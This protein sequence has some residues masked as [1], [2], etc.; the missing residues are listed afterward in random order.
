[1]RFGI[2]Y[3]NIQTIMFIYHWLDI[4]NYWFRYHS[5]FCSGRLSRRLSSLTLCRFIVFDFLSEVCFSCFGTSSAVIF[6]SR[7]VR[8][9]LK[10]FSSSSLPHVRAAMAW[11]VGRSTR[12]FSACS[13]F[14]VFIVS[15]IFVKE[16][17]LINEVGNMA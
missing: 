2:L 13:L 15:Y 11:S 14:I 16:N 17:V 7:V 8:F 6:W 5:F 3:A 1:M 10:A 9:A 4:M 12:S